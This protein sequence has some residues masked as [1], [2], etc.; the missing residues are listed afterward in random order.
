MQRPAGIFGSARPVLCGLRIQR[1]LRAVT[2][3]ARRRRCKHFPM[4]SQPSGEVQGRTAQQ[5]ARPTTHP[6]RLRDLKANAIAYVLS[7]VLAW[8]VWVAIGVSDGT[9]WPWPALVTVFWGVAVARNAWDVYSR[10]R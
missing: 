6:R 9:W 2:D 3:A 4:G 8:T 5:A 7:N 1:H 10:T